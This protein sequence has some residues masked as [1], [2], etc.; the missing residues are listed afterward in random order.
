MSRFPILPSFSK[1]EPNLHFDETEKKSLMNRKNLARLQRNPQF[2]CK[3]RQESCSGAKNKSFAMGGQLLGKKIKQNE[4]LTTATLRHLEIK[5][6]FFCHD[7]GK[8]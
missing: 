5:V 7:A 1:Q 2:G 8:T 3:H 6:G 4:L